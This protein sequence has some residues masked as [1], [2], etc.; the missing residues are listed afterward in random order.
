MKAKNR[1][2]LKLLLI[3]IPILPF[4][5]ALSA[6]IEIDKLPK[7]NQITLHAGDSYRYF[8]ATDG[9]LFASEE[10]H[11]W[12]RSLDSRMPATMVSKTGNGDLYAFVLGSGLLHY[13]DKQNSWSMVN[14]QFGA[15]AI[16]NLSGDSSSAE[17][18]L[19]LNQF[20]KPIVSNDG[21]GSWHSINGPYKPASDVERN[22]QTLYQQHCQ[23]CHGIDGVGETYSLQ[24]LTDKNY[25]RAPALNYSEHAWHHTDDQLVKTILEGSP[26]TSKMPAFGKTGLSQQ[27]ARDLVAYLKSLW[28]ERE[29]DCQGPKHM[30]CMN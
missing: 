9:G 23:S 27:N 19:A 18:L 2:M 15:Q 5:A 20:G 29:L 22:G 8:A 16:M 25:L 6:G 24:S 12:I 11:I 14:N 7:I 17:Q 1:S 21:G 28:T 3:L 30:Q 26:R 13:Q 4:S 10:G